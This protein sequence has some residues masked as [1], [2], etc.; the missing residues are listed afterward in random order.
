MTPSVLQAIN[1]EEYTRDVEIQ[2]TRSP[3]EKLKQGGAWKI[4][5]KK[6]LQWSYLSHNKLFKEKK[7]YLTVWIGHKTSV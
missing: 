3:K 5:E 1:N 4:T 6:P 7:L 2:N